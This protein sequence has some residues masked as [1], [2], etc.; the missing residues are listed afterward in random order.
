VE[1]TFCYLQ[2]NLPN[3]KNNI[4][5]NKEYKGV[6]SVCFSG[7]GRQGNS[8]QFMLSMER[9]ESNSGK[10]NNSPAFLKI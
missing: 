2:Y 10:N 1:L 8:E 9:Q 6:I 3:I 4:K 7:T 5:Y